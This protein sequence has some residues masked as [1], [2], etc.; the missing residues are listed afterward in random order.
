LI[1]GTSTFSDFSPLAKALSLVLVNQTIGALVINAGF[2]LVFSRLSGLL[3]PPSNRVV[4]PFRT[5]LWTTLV[6]S[7]TVWP[8]A[9]F[10]NFYFVPVDYRVLYTSCIAA[11]YN[12]LLSYRM[13]KRND[14]DKVN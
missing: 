10:V 8:V 1:G 2:V 7:W 4:Q 3:L 11:V 9:S 13:N 12:F 14:D 5:R 6:T